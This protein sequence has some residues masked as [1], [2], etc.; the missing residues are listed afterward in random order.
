MAHGRRRGGGAGI[1]AITL[2]GP[3]QGHALFEQGLPFRPDWEAVI[4]PVHHL[5]AREDVDPGRV[6]LHGISQA[7]YWVP[8]AVAFE[9]RIAAA[10]ADPGVMDVSTSWTDH[11][12]ARM[13]REIDEGRSEKFDRDL[14]LGLKFSRYARRQL[15]FR[16]RPYGVDDAY[17]A[18][19]A[20]R[21]YHLRDVVGR[22]T[23]PM[24]ITDPDDEQF[25]PGQPQEFYDALGGPK[26][27]VRFTREEGADGHCEPM[28][29]GL[30]DQCVFDWLDETL[31][32]TA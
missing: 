32:V 31:G 18:F 16:M 10:V 24:L 12:P 7:G 6:A 4:T 22:I 19:R 28:A 9:H 27:L 2:D 8:R 13:V 26:R 23:C 29:L 15:A 1:P 30:R 21:Q 14:A 5:L 20:V 3:G 17:E 25:W 11:L